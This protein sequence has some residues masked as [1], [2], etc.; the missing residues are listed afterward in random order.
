MALLTTLDRVKA[1]AVADTFIQGLTVA[2]PI[3]AQVFQYVQNRVNEDP[4]GVHQQEA[5]DYLAAHLL[6]SAGQPVGGRGP[7][8]SRTVGR[9]TTSFT[10]PYLNQTKQE[11]MT[12]YGLRY[13]GIMDEVTAAFDVIVTI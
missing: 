13:L 11:G 10:L 9:V 5:Q 2:S 3:V 12:Q 6:S 4:W 8:S 7:V 1:I